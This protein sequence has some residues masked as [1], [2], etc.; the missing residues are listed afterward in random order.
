MTFAPTRSTLQAGERLLSGPRP[1]I[2]GPYELLFRSFLRD[3]EDSTA[4]LMTFY[5]QARLEIGD[6]IGNLLGQLP[7]VDLDHYRSLQAGLDEILG[8]LDAGAAKWADE[9]ISRAY[10]AGKTLS[11]TPD[12]TTIHDEAVRALSRGTLD[13]ITNTSA[14]V[15]RAVQQEVSQALI[16][17]IGGPE[18]IARIMGSGL[19]AGPWK[20]I[21]ERAGVIARTETMRA[22][23]GG[24][25]AGITESGAYLVR[26]ITSEDE[27]VCK[28]CGPRDG[29]VYRIAKI[30]DMLKGDVRIGDTD[31]DWLMARPRLDE[32]GGPPPAHPR[33]RCTIA[34]HFRGP[35]GK[36]LGDPGAEDAAARAA[37]V[38]DKE[39][40]AAIAGER[41]PRDFDGELDRLVTGSWRNDPEALAFWRKHGPLSGPQLDRIANGN[42]L[43]FSEFMQAR[44]GVKVFEQG[45]RVVRGRHKLT[46]GRSPS[47]N[48]LAKNAVM[49]R[50]AL[51][52]FEEFHK[53]GAGRFVN[54]LEEGMDGNLYL[55]VFAPSGQASNVLAS[56]SVDGWIMWDVKKGLDFAKLGSLRAGDKVNGVVETLVHEIGH[57]I[58]NRFGYYPQFKATEA[59]VATQASRDA[60]WSSYRE[61]Q[62]R[63]GRWIAGWKETGRGG[64]AGGEINKLQAELEMKLNDLTILDRV[65]TDATFARERYDSFLDGLRS[66]YGAERAKTYSPTFDDWLSGE[67]RRRDRFKYETDE[68]FP[69]IE[70]AKKIADEPIATFGEHYPTEYGK[71]ST[72]EDFA[73]SVALYMLNPD[74]LRIYSPARYHFL[75]EHVFEGQGG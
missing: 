55:R 19:T 4:R 65:A 54:A 37:E 48:L 24:N 59:S 62:A 50:H 51:E 34:A 1:A 53:I 9:S 3:E 23:N 57:S 40:A 12:F 70:E 11:G 16:G 30:G 7:Q 2:T 36:V 43:G 27:R 8:E 58:H 20:T 39:L 72:A 52:A 25:M 21:E 22:F 6:Y 17:S 5:Q 47:Y 63:T 74:R 28:V 41:P 29:T 35:D 71:Q 67:V 68:L 14:D 32:I 18:L 45:G 42:M 60:F 56:C 46:A 31:R 69:K 10:V 64:P 66:A 73:E 13:L 75:R 44:Y 33:C 61:I 38:D 49:R 26:W 15:R